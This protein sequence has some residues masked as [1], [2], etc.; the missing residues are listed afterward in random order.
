LNNA[1]AKLSEARENGDLGLVKHWSRELAFHGSGHYLHSIFWN[2]MKPNGGGEPSGELAEAIIRDFGSFEAFKAQFIAAA[3]QVEGS[4][5]AI[6]ACKC[7]LDGK[8]SILQS[9]K[10][11]NLTQW[12]VTPLLVLDVWEHAY[13]LKYQNRRPEYTKAFFN[14]INWEDVE[15]RYGEGKEGC[16]C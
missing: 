9:E 14:V 1:E 15:K 16:C 6:L 12:G 11:Q 2:N 4:G 13:Y 7:D 5:W 8:L 10:H 3:N